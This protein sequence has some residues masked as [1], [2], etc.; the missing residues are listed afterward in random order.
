MTE[1]LADRMSSFGRRVV[2]RQHTYRTASTVIIMSSSIKYVAAAGWL[3]TL[4]LGGYSV[5][6]LYFFCR[7]G[8]ITVFETIFYA[9]FGRIIYAVS[10]GWIA[11]A[12][13]T[14]YGGTALT[15]VL[16]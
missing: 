5:F 14:G 6:G 13:S 15:F 10:L 2:I 7:D 11:F 12:C 4:V 1:K 8:A 9:L 16:P 3:A